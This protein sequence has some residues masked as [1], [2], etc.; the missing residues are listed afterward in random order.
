MM[1]KTVC[2]PQCGSK[3]LYKDGLR[4]LKDGDTVQ[5]WLCRECDYRFSDP[6][7][8][9]DCCCSSVRNVQKIPTSSLKTSD[10]I[11]YGCQVGAR[12]LGGAKNLVELKSR[13]QKQA[14]GATTKDAEIKGKVVEFAWALKRDGLSNK[15][16]RTYTAYLNK[17]AQLGAD[18]L[19]P[20]SVKQAMTIYENWS[21]RTKTFAV[22][23][24]KKFASVNDINWKP[25]RYKTSRKLPF[26]PLEREVDALIAGTGKK[27]S[28]VLQLLK[29]TGMRIGEALEVRWTD[30]DLERNR[31]L[32]NTPEK[33][34]RP[35]CFKMSINLIS[36]LSSLPKVNEKIFGKTTYNS[37]QTNFLHQRRKLAIKLQNPRLK[38]IRFHNL[39][40]WK[41][42]MEYHRTKDILHVMQVLGHKK[43]ENTLIYTQLVDFE[44]EDDFHSATARTVKEAKEL[45]EAGFSYVCD[46][47]G[48]KLFRKRK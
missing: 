15:T 4:Y 24:Y 7:D 13:I 5:R 17:L 36:M 41:A 38:Q 27:I 31:I 22:A 1:T 26:I 21:N 32:V 18:L 6:S 30:L 14:A 46:I 33:G 42:T 2:C 34:G 11:P 19:Y 35:R 45:V 23:V 39:R 9:E 20:E 8:K 37:L 44:D 48:V 3:S 47:E 25:P 12:R 28:T 43:I 16:I 29:E 10:S 40:H